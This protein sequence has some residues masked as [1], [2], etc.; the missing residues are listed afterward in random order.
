MNK[1]FSIISSL[2]LLFFSLDDNPFRLYLAFPWLVYLLWNIYS[3]RKTSKK[4]YLY[5]IPILI[6][7][8]SSFYDKSTS[9]FFYPMINQ[10]I[11]LKNDIYI[12]EKHRGRL[13]SF[14]DSNT[15]SVAFREIKI[16]KNEIVKIVSFHREGY[17][18]GFVMGSPN[19]N[20]RLITP[21]NKKINQEF[22]AELNNN[23]P[24]L[25]WSNSFFDNN[26]ILN[27]YLIFN[28]NRSWNYFF[29]FINL[30]YFF[31]TLFF[32]I[33]IFKPCILFFEDKL[34]I[35]LISVILYIVAYYYVFFTAINDG[36]SKFILGIPY[37]IFLI[38]DIRFFKRKKIVVFSHIFVLLISGYF[39]L[40]D[41]S[42]N[43]FIYPLVNKT[44]TVSKDINY[45]YGGF[46]VNELEILGQY[47]SEKGR[48]IFT[49]KSGNT[50]E[51][52]K[53]IVT[54]HA[55]FGISYTFE[56]DSPN[57]IE[58]KQYIKNNLDPIKVYYFFE[59]RNKIYISEYD[60]SDLMKSQ[61]IKYKENSFNNDFIYI[62]F[63]IFI[64]PII[65]LIFFF[66][67][68]YRN[69]TINTNSIV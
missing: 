6:F 13:L 36:F 64:Y 3:F 20:I 65:L 11:V 62:S 45:T 63:F 57:F 34:K 37:A 5:L 32:F 48:K 27:K 7:I 49:L 9:E 35:N 15:S 56:I 25:I 68:N 14:S 23:E 61:V 53:Q 52:K 39:L 10:E 54:G 19:Y 12:G 59:D 67:A 33:C 4:L 46:Y 43:S 17:Y 30:F 38:S 69:E 44:Y 22:F 42:A 21:I 1:Y 55:D 16:S 8:C 51:L 18:F 24:I 26:K 29:I 28:Y 40:F 66:L 50:F 31:A 60:L 58:V 47:S 2:Y 41:K